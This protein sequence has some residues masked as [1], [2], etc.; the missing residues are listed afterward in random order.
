MCALDAESQRRDV[1]ALRE[2]Q[3]ELEETTQL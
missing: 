2:S 3:Q 1:K